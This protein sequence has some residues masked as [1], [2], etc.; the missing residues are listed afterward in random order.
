MPRTSEF[1]GL[2]FQQIE[3]Q[4]FRSDELNFCSCNKHL[5]SSYLHQEDAVKENSQESLP[6]KGTC[7]SCEI[8]EA[9]CTSISCV[10]A[11]NDLSESTLGSYVDLIRLELGKT[12]RHALKDFTPL[13]EHITSAQLASSSL[14]HDGIDGI[15]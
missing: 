13:E 15:E 14:D 4:T 6:V 10:R 3:Q 8:L 2:N 12:P 7:D 1:T 5:L 11:D 9:R